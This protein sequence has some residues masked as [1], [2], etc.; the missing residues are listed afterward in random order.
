MKIADI[1][2]GKEYI[3][4]VPTRVIVKEVGLP[5]DDGRGGT[6]AA[7]VLAQQVDSGMNVVVRC[8]RI[9]DPETLPFHRAVLS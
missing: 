6:R 3:V 9:K 5:M 7:G 4:L 1:K 8:D 2:E